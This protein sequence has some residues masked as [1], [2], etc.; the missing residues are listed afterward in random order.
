MSID[1]PDESAPAKSATDHWEFPRLVADMTFET[2]LA[3][4]TPEPSLTSSIVREILASAPAYV[5][6]TTSRL[7]PDYEEESSDKFNLGS[8]A[9]QVLIGGGRAVRWLDFPAYRSN[10]AKAARDAVYA[11]GQTPLLEKYREPTYAMADR[12]REQF[13][14]NPDIG[15]MFAD[16]FDRTVHAESSVF[17]RERAIT[18]RA[19]P[20]LFAPL[21]R[22]D[23][24]PPIIV[25]YKTTGERLSAATL[26]R[27]CS[28]MQWHLT[29]SHYAAGIGILTNRTPRQ[30]FAVQ[31]NKPPFLARVV[32]L[33]DHA[34][35][36][37]DML[38]E[39]AMRQWARCVKSGFW[40]GHAAATLPVA[41]PPWAENTA[42]EIKDR[43]NETLDDRMMELAEGAGLWP[44]AGRK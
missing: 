29:A 3:D 40:P 15:W 36:V 30:F 12:A 16:E 38:R 7:N 26:P 4:P 31:Q 20:D 2:Y 8:A 1:A 24:S 44:A 41:L 37:G 22:A 28:N 33:D 39:T 19:R 14:Q 13:R 35:A 17:W 10:A 27:Y 32:E 11:A 43:R 23:D 34:L 21:L 18:C 25:H 42:V 5:R 6:E 9:H